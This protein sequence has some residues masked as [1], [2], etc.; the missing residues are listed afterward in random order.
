[1]T[2]EEAIQHALDVAENSE[3]CN[4]CAAEHK[5]L[6]EWLTELK[7]LKDKAKC[8]IRDSEL[9]PCPFCGGKACL[10]RGIY[11]NKEWHNDFI[12][13]CDKCEVG[14][15]PYNTMAEAIKAWNR[16]IDS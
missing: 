12:V 5:Q 8:K 14:T 6:A 11:V 4:S 9:K 10:Q 2:L 7:E 1:M 3:I 16:R 13:F 15:V